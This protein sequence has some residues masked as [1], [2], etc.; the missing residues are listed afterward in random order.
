MD[1]MRSAGVAKA[2]QFIEFHLCPA[3]SLHHEVCESRRLQ[4]LR[5][6]GEGGWF[7]NFV[8]RNRHQGHRGTVS[9]VEACRQMCSLF[10]DPTVW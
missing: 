1:S 6:T 5:D 8:E 2:G 4:R 9:G 10:I 7:L 3:S